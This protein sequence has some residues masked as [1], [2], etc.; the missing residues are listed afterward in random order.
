VID[1]FIITTEQ[2]KSGKPTL[3]VL[4]DQ[5]KRYLHSKINPGNESQI[6]RKEIEENRA[7]LIIILGFGLGYH[8]ENNF[9]I[10]RGRRVIVIDH[11]SLA[12]NSEVCN[13]AAKFK[14]Q[15]ENF[16]YIAES[17]V[18]IEETLKKYINVDNVSVLSV[19]PHASSYRIFNAYF[20]E[21]EA[22]IRELIDSKISNKATINKFADLFFKNC[23]KR[24][25][26]INKY[27]PV[28]SLYN[29]FTEYSTIIVS[30]SPTAY[31]QLILIRKLSEHYFIIAVD[32]AV[33]MLMDSG[34][35]PDFIISIDPQ[36]WISE[37]LLGYNLSQSVMIENLT[38]YP[39]MA[40]GTTNHFLAVNTH[41]LGQLIEELFDAKIGSVDSSTGNVAG[42]AL[43]FALKLGFKE[44]V[45][46]GVDL[47]FP[48]DVIY[49]SGTA[50]QNRFS[51][52][53]N[54]RFKP[55]ESWNS[56]YIFHVSGRIKSNGVYTRRNFET[57]RKLLI[58]KF[59]SE[60]SVFQLA[61]SLHTPLFSTIS[62]SA[63]NSVK[64][65]LKKEKIIKEV[66]ESKKPSLIDLSLVKNV[67]LNT[68]VLERVTQA[69]FISDGLKKKL[70]TV[71]NKL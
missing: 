62:E 28:S 24:F 12:E 68:T 55:V 19:I 67:L 20:C 2:T 1:S 5:K 54:N 13:A 21:V 43:S 27:Y 60:S 45:I 35:T 33:P 42:D 4:T 25:S 61:D 34:I 53:F 39:I 63:L 15:S 8:L 18:L 9:D 52:F 29:Q 6:F 48:F 44:V 37:H 36:P 56:S 14:T 31:N 17:A 41:P 32:S 65:I 16:Y 69:S 71:I 47:S 64:F 10:L 22:I 7:G 3:A 11:P 40:N 57:Y 51:F 70:L 38:A 59:A 26:S 46:A 58:N 49:A 23:L 66:I 30:S 50:Y